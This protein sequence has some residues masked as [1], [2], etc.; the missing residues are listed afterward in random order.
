MVYIVD[1]VLK[2]L[3]YFPDVSPEVREKL[4]L[5]FKRKK[6]FIFLQEQLKTL[7]IETYNSIALD[8]PHRLI[9]ALEVCISSGLPYSSF[10]N[11]T[12]TPRN[13]K[14]VKIGLTADREIIYNR[15]NQR[16]EIMLTNGLENEAKKT[17]PK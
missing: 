2:G 8:N 13:F 5:R 6:G 15:I 14:S 7:D 1:A 9:R 12:K 17:L 4:K 3:D 10:K 16:V 11:K